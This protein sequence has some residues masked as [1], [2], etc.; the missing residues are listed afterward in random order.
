MEVTHKVGETLIADT[1][2]RKQ[3]NEIIELL[4]SKKQTYA[5]NKFVLEK[6]IENLQE[7]IV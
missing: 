1:E 3:V 5:A 6:T 2:V 4:K 7:T